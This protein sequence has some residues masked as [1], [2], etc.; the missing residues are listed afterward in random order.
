[1]RKCG[2]IILL[3]FALALAPAAGASPYSQVLQ[4]YQSTGSVPACQFSSPQLAAALKGVDT[5][6][7]Q[8]FADFSDAI[9]NALAA[10]A[11]GACAAGGHHALTAGTAPQVPLP[12]SATSATNARLPLVLLALAGLTVLLAVATLAN[13]LIR[14]GGWEPGWAAAWHHAWGEVS[15]RM[16]G[17]LA[18]LADRW[19]RH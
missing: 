9:Q 19:R 2:A 17:G 10:R 13:A 5:Y 1:V 7:Q 16:A 15:Y 6:G 4:A 11:A 8:Y 12:A 14:G 3:L 18:D